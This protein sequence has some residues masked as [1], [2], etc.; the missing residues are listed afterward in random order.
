M[1]DQSTPTSSGDAALALDGLAIQA[2]LDAPLAAP[3]TKQPANQRA[4]HPHPVALQV[5]RPL[6][7]AKLAFVVGLIV[8]LPYLIP[9]LPDLRAQPEYRFTADDIQL[10]PAP[11]LPTPINL[12]EQIRRQNHLPGEMSLLDPDL[13]KKLSTAFS[14]HL[15]IA[16]VVSVEKM[17]PAVV[18]VRV[19]YRR[20]VA[21]VQVKGG[22]V[23]IDATGT[24][25][26]SEDFGLEDVAKFPSIRLAG[27]SNLVA[28]AGRFKD[29]GLTGA[30]QI[31]ELLGSKWD[32]LGLEAIELPRTAEKSQSPENIP[33]QLQT[34]VGST[35]IWGRAPGTDH[36]G[37]LT[38]AQKIARLEKYLAEFGG[39]ARPNGPYEIDI[40]HWQEITR[41]PSAKVQTSSRRDSR[42]RY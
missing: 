33:F 41:R 22:R 28:Q 4:R 21:M 16:R 40:R 34:K 8:F 12:V 27:S 20:P 13:C 24:V 18:V 5:F 42:S 14:T 6:R 7:L 35:I 30:V 2:D 11:K 10:A 39:F 29:R 38:A 36:P 17:F 3:R 26:P 15:W 1:A 9:R 25:L 23:P 19:E 37:E 32:A 31:A